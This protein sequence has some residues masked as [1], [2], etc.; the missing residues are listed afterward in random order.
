MRPYDEVRLYSPQETGY[1][2]CGDLFLQLDFASVD[3]YVAYL[4]FYGE[5]RAVKDYDVSV[6]SNLQ[7]ADP[8]GD[9]DMLRRIDGDGAEGVI[10]IHSSLDRHSGAKGQ[11][12]KR[13]YRSVGNDGDVAAGLCQDSRGL[14]GLILKLE[15]GGMSK[16]RPYG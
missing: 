12:V 11:V 2:F 16:G 5:G 7:G 10:F 14:P 15:L 9:A 13:D 6:L 8:V 3:E 1:V 4:A